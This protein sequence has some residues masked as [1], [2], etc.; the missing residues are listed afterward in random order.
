MSG[1]VMDAI[2]G[3]DDGALKAMTAEASS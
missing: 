2:G 1:P 3:G